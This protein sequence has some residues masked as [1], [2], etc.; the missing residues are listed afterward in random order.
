MIGPDL[1]WVFKKRHGPNLK[2]NH[3]RRRTLPYQPNRTNHTILK[4]KKEYYENIIEVPQRSQT[5][6]RIFFSNFETPKLPKT[7]GKKMSFQCELSVSC[8]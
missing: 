8:E 1:Q 2:A 5:I 4:S 3:Q 6:S 7:A